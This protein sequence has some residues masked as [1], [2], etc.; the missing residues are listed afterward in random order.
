MASPSFWLPSSF[1]GEHHFLETFPHHQLLGVHQNDTP[2]SIPEEYFE[3]REHEGGVVITGINQEYFD[4]EE[5]S[6]NWN[7]VIPWVIHWQPVVEIGTSV[8]RGLSITSVRFPNTIVSIWNRAFSECRWLRSVEFSSA[9]P[10]FCGHEAFAGTQLS[11]PIDNLRAII[12]NGAI[13]FP[14]GCV[15]EQVTFW[16]TPDTDMVI[17]NTRWDV[18]NHLPIYIAPPT[19]PSYYPPTGEPPD[20]SNTSR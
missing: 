19:S 17:W 10:I 14:S 4:K 6:I 2:H 7:I 20:F 3:T 8:F 11:G 1:A 13:P 12:P 18:A 15:I 9:N 5:W 16:L